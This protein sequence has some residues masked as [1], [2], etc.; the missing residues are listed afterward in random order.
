MPF[1]VALVDFV[2]FV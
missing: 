1:N 2:V